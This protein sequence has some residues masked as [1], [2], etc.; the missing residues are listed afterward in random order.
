[1]FYQ[2]ISKLMIKL[3]L[4]ALTLTRIDSRLYHFMT[5]NGI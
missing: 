3:M 5:Y 2:I 1:M 4:K